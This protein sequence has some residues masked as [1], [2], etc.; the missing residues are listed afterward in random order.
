MR[1]GWRALLLCVSLIY[2]G[3]FAMPAMAA[4]AT[5]VEGYADALLQQQLHWAPG[6]YRIGIRGGTLQVTPPPGWQG[7]V[8]EVRK[9]LEVVPGVQTVQVVRGAEVAGTG[10]IDLPWLHL[11][12]GSFFPRGE[13]F[14]PLVADP[15]EPR[16]FTSYRVYWTPYGAHHL[17]AVGYG[18]TLGL[19]R[20]T[21]GPA[22]GQLQ[23][24]FAAGAFSQFNLDVA[25]PQLLNTDFTVGIPLTWRRGSDSLRVSFYHQSSHLGPRFFAQYRPTDYALSYEA[26]SAL[27]SHDW[28][29]WRVYGGGAYLLWPTPSDLK[30]EQLQGG[31]EFRG[32][33]ILRGFARVIAGLDVKS[34]SETDWNPDAS[35]KLGLEYAGFDPARRTLS[36]MLEAYSGHMPHG[37]FYKFTTDYVGIGAY[38]GF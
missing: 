16:F 21:Q 14:R 18:G 25:S 35:L 12:G 37:Q 11:A 13:L 30:P 36:V 5:Y 1:F 6:S 3:F 7:R 27:W 2:S 22:G 34:W 31:I 38:L 10:S 4:D 23:M 9:T 28:G 15:K 29:S 8:V 20:W 19:Y 32:Q 24:D 17:G 26:L 33:R